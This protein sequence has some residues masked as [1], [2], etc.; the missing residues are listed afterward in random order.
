MKRI[1]HRS[2][3]ERFMSGATGGLSWWPGWAR[4]DFHPFRRNAKLTETEQPTGTEG[5]RDC[6]V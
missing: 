5:G 3:A 4:F 1:F 6:R 2:D